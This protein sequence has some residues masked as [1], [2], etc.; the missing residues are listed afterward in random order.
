MGYDE[1]ITLTEEIKKRAVTSVMGAF[2]LCIK[3][4][5]LRKEAN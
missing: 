5:F 4:G 2:S 1:E 3:K